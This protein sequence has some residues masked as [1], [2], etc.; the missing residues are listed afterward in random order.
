MKKE[1]L[2]LL[3]SGGHAKCVLDILE[4]MDSYEIIGVTTQ[5]ETRKDF[6]GYPILG[7]N[8]TLQDL[9]MEGIRYIALG[10]G[11]YTDN[12]QRK[13]LY[14]KLKQLGFTVVSAIHPSAMISKTVSLGEGN[15]IFS[16]V[17]MIP[18]VQV[19]NNVVIASG[20]NIGHEVIIEDHVLISTG[21]TTGANIKIQEGALIS[22][23]ATIVSGVTVGK[24][25][26]VAAGAVVV[27]DIE[28]NTKVFG[29]PARP[30]ISD[31]SG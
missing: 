9:Y 16:G 25:A 20:S 10:V 7:N 5:D 28:E 26:F 11:G 4:E 14:T 8:E 23:G 1:K 17:I 30:K 2:V 24:N 29:I 19:G 3:G 15:I 27:K 6:C 18:D 31:Y 12:N 22:M 13:A 21:V